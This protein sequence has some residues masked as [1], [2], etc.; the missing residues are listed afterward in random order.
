MCVCVHACVCVLC[1]KAVGG[2]TCAAHYT[3]GYRMCG[4][5]I[6]INSWEA[7][8]HTYIHTY[9]H[10]CTHTHTHT[11]AYLCQPILQVVNQF[12]LICFFRRLRSDMDL[13]RGLWHR[14]LI[15]CKYAYTHTFPQTLLLYE[16]AS[17][18][19]I[20]TYIYAWTHPLVQAP[21]LYGHIL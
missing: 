3:T 16:S 1:T 20:Y 4:Y 14:L 11:Q 19:L 21:L 10:T 6:Y 9:I 17:R 12:I 15:K 8:I 13:P 5:W 18:S 2:G 7:C